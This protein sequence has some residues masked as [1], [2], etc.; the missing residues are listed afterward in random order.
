MLVLEAWGNRGSNLCTTKRTNTFLDKAEPSSKA[1][2]TSFRASSCIARKSWA[3]PKFIMYRDK[4]KP[5]FRRETF[6]N[7]YRYHFINGQHNNNQYSVILLNHLGAIFYYIP[8]TLFKKADKRWIQLGKTSIKM[9]KL[10]AVKVL[11]IL[12]NWH[13]ITQAMTVG[14]QVGYYLITTEYCKELAFVHHL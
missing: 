12:K 11:S 14:Y 7:F 2:R 9:N 8:Y 5:F 6:N 13:G 3:K 4:I 10:L 1:R